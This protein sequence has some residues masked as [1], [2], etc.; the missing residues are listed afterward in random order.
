MLLVWGYEP[1]RNFREVCSMSPDRLFVWEIHW[2]QLGPASWVDQGLTVFYL[3][4]FR[5]QYSLKIK[6]PG[7]TPESS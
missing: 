6:K 3:L 4:Y 7:I 1:F 2:Q 5:R